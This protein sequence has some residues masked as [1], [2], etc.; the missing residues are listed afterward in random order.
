MKKIIAFVLSVV[1]GA[2]AMLPLAGCDQEPEKVVKDEYTFTFDMN[3]DGAED[4]VTTV[5]AGYR[6]NYYNA[7]RSGYELENWYLTEDGSGDP[8]DFSIAIDQDYVVYAQWNEVGDPVSVTFNYNFENCPSPVTITGEEGKAIGSSNLPDYTRLGYDL[9]GW[10]TDAACTQEWDI[11]KSLLTGDLSLYAKYE[12]TANLQFDSNDDVILEDV[13]V[14]ISVNVGSWG[15]A[16]RGLTEIV[17]RF[18]EAYEGK[19]RL[20]W[21]D[22]FSSEV[23]RFEDPGFINQYPQNNYSM[24]ELLSLVKIDFDES[25]YYPDAIRE[26]Y[27]DG[28]LKTFPVGHMAPSLMYNKSIL[29][30]INKTEADLKTH[31]GIVEALKAAET[32]NAD[33]A[34]YVAS[35]VYESAEWQWHEMSANNIWSNNGLTYYSYDSATGSYVNNFALAENENAAIDAIKGFV[36]LFGNDAISVSG[37]AGFDAQD[38]LKNIIDGKSFMGVVGYSRIYTDILSAYNGQFLNKVGIIPITNLFNYG[39]TKN[40][41]TF[42]K[43]ISIALPNDTTAVFDI[44]QLAAVAVFCEFLEDN[45][46]YLAYNDTIPASKTS[47][48]KVDEGD[49]QSKYFKITKM[50]A[51]PS[52]FI[53]LPGHTSEYF[54]YNYQ[55]QAYVSA[56]KQLTVADLANEEILKQTVRSIADSIGN[57]I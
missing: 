53:T 26:N 16:K 32:A 51:D 43:G 46:Q 42:V 5:K 19:I 15:S 49:Y 13:E 25:N 10:Y 21:V 11:D 31:E 48:A 41:K 52:T 27:V 34:D 33:N 44:E 9:V 37:E 47:Q 56:L 30:Q 20:N 1:L 17:D 24:G 12:Y 22:A 55:S 4:R 3:Y 28:T 40:A 38:G 18:N 57:V 54:F 39:N 8:F 6:A 45:S 29:Q 7:R 14:D 2:A 23:M 36:N 50:L 35:L